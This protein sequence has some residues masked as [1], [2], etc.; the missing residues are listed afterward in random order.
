M[1]VPRLAIAVL[2]GSLALAACHETVGER[3]ESLGPHLHRVTVD[4]RADAPAEVR[5]TRAAQA[6]CPAGFGVESD[7]TMPPDD[8]SYR[9]WLVRC[10]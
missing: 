10:K 2:F 6:L 9:V 5:L 8:P 4:L 1:A 3:E 7:E